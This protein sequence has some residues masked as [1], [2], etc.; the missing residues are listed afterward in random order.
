VT[1][2]KYD[3]LLPTLFVGL[4]FPA[5]AGGWWRFL[6]GYADQPANST[7]YS[8]LAEPA[9]T[10]EVSQPQHSVQ[11][12]G[13]ITVRSAPATGRRHLVASN[14]IP[15]KVVDEPLLDVSIVNDE[16]PED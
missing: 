2:P 3:V 15:T 6:S 7:V 5:A 10:E 12:A 9:T 4:I 1:L 16:F 8:Q 13:P 14:F 11:I